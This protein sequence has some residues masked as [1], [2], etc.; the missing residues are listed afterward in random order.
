MG[1]AEV[2]LYLTGRLNAREKKKETC[3]MIGGEEEEIR[4]P[5]GHASYRLE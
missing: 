2:R 1:Y 3:I 5:L 4:Q